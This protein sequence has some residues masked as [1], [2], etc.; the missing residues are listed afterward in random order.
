MEIIRLKYP[1]SLSKLRSENR[2]PARF[3]VSFEVSPAP[4]VLL[5]AGVFLPHGENVAR[6]VDFSLQVHN[7]QTLAA[8]VTI[9]VDRTE[10]FKH[11]QMCIDHKTGARSF[12]AFFFLF[13][14]CFPVLQR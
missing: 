10:Q 7:S 5:G 14:N 13:T 12:P 6:P 11:S 1:G 2:G 4:V 8:E 3:G 9:S